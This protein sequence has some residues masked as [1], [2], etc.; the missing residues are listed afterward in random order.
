MLL[1]IDAGNSY[2]KFALFDG[3]QIRATVRIRNH[4]GE[5]ADGFAVS[6][7]GAGISADLVDAV[8]IG[9]V[10]PAVTPILVE[11]VRAQLTENV[12]VAKYS[13]DIGL[14]IDYDRPAS[15]GID[16][17]ADTLAAADVLGAPSIAVDMGT[18]TTFN[19]VTPGPRFAGGVIAPGIGV[20][21]ETLASRTAQLHEVS[22][23]KPHTVIA[24]STRQALQSGLFY[25]YAS[26]VEGIVRRLQAEQGIDG[27]P[28][29]A[30]GG[31]TLVEH[32][33]DQCPSVTRVDVNLTLRGL[34]LLYKARTKG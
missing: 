1:V 8:A 32:L 5:T 2:L 18:A 30:T 33:I 23:S 4:P 12:Y 29:I 24:K 6:V 28:V 31:G 7:L 16:R 19:V 26:M 9:S 13:D 34:R 3:D 21:S 27:C 20:L 14:A 22:P 10:V 15:L 11:F 17:L 25:G